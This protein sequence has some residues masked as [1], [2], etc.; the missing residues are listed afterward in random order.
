MM[1]TVRFECPQCGQWIEPLIPPVDTPT[2]RGPAEK[3]HLRPVKM[4][5]TEAP[6]RKA[7][8]TKKATPARRTGMIKRR[9]R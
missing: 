5:P 4:V 6:Q 2:C 3:R 9:Q 8:A 1:T 7:R